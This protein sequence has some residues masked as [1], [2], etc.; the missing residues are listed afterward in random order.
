MVWKHKDGR[1]IK[2]GKAW[3]MHP[4]NWASSWSDADKKRLGLTWE[5]LPASAKPYDTAFY[6]GRKT[7]GD[8]IERSLTDTKE[9]DE[10]GKPIIDLETKK[11]IISKGLKTIWIE[12]TKQKT[13]SYLSKWDWQVTRKYEKD[14]AIDSDVSAYRDAVRTACTNIEKAINDCSSLSDFQA[15][16]VTPKDSDGTVTGKAPIDNFPDEI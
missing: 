16:F 9:V 4:Y 6:S 15:L 2:E 7:N 11:Q 3:D 10:D 8:L 5:D 1:I 12:K 13:N 14:I